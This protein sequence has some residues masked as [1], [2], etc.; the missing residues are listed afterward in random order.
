ML[1][2]HFELTDI[3]DLQKYRYPDKSDLEILSMI[4]EW[5]KAGC[6]GRYFEMFTVVGGGAPVG[7]VSI[8]EHNQNTVSVGVHIFEPFRHKNYASFAITEAMKIAANK[9]YHFAISLI[10]KHNL[11]AIDLFKNL[12]FDSVGEFIDPKGNTMLTYKKYVAE[13]K[14]EGAKRK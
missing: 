2:R 9:G 1:I 6:S 5:N 10:E 12:G 11:P 8:Y 4:N 13:M 14:S 7:E 3:K